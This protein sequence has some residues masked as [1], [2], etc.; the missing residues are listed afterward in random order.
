LL[1]LRPIVVGIQPLFAAMPGA[2]NR[3]IAAR[4]IHISS[5]GLGSAWPDEKTRLLGRIAPN[6]HGMAY[7]AMHQLP[8]DTFG[9]TRHAIG[10]APPTVGDIVA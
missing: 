3:I 2:Q 4:A 6:P 5:R 8:S 7:G 9:H 10:G 1:P